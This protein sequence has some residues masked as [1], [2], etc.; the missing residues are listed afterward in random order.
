MGSAFLQLC[1]RYSGSLTPTAPTAMRLWETFTFFPLSGET[2]NRAGRR[3]LPSQSDLFLV[4]PD[5]LE[6]ERDWHGFLFIMYH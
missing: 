2:R 3:G 1:P 4:E 6:I 5:K